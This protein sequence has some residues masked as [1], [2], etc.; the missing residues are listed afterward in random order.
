MPPRHHLLPPILLALLASVVT[1]GHA[2]AQGPPTPTVETEA[3][4]A[5]PS[6][7]EITDWITRVDAATLS[8]DAKK[9]LKDAYSVTL[10]FVQALTKSKERTAQLEALREDAPRKLAEEIQPAL[11]KPAPTLPTPDPTATLAQWEQEAN[12]AK[13]GKDAAEKTVTDLEEEKRKRTEDRTANPLATQTATSRITE[14]ERDLDSV[15]PSS[16]PLDPNFAR[17]QR[18][19]AERRLLKQRLVELKAELVSY[20]ARSELLIRRGELAAKLRKEAVDL[21]EHW[22][23]HV[24]DRRA[25]DAKDEAERAS[26]SQAIAERLGL[27]ALKETTTRNL[28]LANK[29][30]GADSVRAKIDIAVQRLAELN[31]ERTKLQTRFE[32][33]RKRVELGLSDTLGQYLHSSRRLVFGSSTVEEHEEEIRLREERLKQVLLEQIELDDEERDLGDVEARVAAAMVE[34]AADLDP[35]RSQLISETLTNAYEDLKKNLIALQV[36]Y[37]DYLN[38]LNDLDAQQKALVKLGE[39]YRQYLTEKILWIRSSSAIGPE[40]L[41]RSGEALVWLGSPMRARDL[42]GAYRL[43]VV[44]MWPYYV[45]FF[46]VLVAIRTAR[47]RLIFRRTAAAEKATV[48]D[49]HSPLTTVLFASLEALVRALP[50]PTTLV[51]LAWRARAATLG[52]SIHEYAMALSSGVVAIAGML[53]SLGVLRQILRVRGLGETTFGWPAAS[54]RSARLSLRGIEGIGAPVVFVHSCF[55]PEHYY[56]DSL[57]RIAFLLLLGIGAFFALRLRGPFQNILSS[58]RNSSKGTAAWTTLFMVT[59]FWMPLVLAG[60]SAWGYHWTATQLSESLIASGWLFM[61]LVFAFTIFDQ[62]FQYHRRLIA[63]ERL[64]RRREEVI[65][66]PT[67]SEVRSDARSEALAAI[68][69][70]PDEV[71]LRRA[72]EQTQSLLRNGAVILFLVGLW[73]IWKDVLPALLILDHVK[74][75]T[76]SV[77]DAEVVKVVDI[78]LVNLLRS[79]FL[80]FLTMIISVNVTGFL[81]LVVLTRLPLVAGTRYAVV[82]LVRYG[83]G[84]TGIALAMNAL[85][86]NWGDLKWLVAA[87]MV[88]LGFGLQEIFGNLVSG[89]ILLL[90]RPVR[91]GDTVTVNGAT[92]VVT[93]IRMRATTIADWDRKELI[94]PNKSFITNDIVNW[95]LTDSVIRVVLPVGVAYG[96]DP[97]KVEDLLMKAARDNRDVLND[98]A[99][100]V[101][102][103]SFGDNSLNFDLRVFVPNIDRLVPARHNMNRAIN[104]LFQKNGVSIPFPQR[105]VHMHIAADSQG[106][107]TVRPKEVEAETT[108]FSSPPSPSPASTSPAATT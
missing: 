65:A 77:T 67:A 3:V 9:S 72:N 73:T 10:G 38:K 93:R 70:E 62:W 97:K 55:G 23:H 47:R 21:S 59:G 78:T 43:D 96:T 99:P 32:Q 53:F 79:I 25:K 5:G 13:A 17:R 66:Q 2:M 95:S 8:E 14:I 48:K 94:I 86:L 58:M 76:V 104:A 44:R 37:A 84:G 18:L 82:T 88:G 89:L 64:R 101:V 15:A 16:D 49:V 30:V 19:V 50:I 6:E 57:G 29:R 34:T 105:D 1:P 33:D 54:L 69:A 56:G 74:L 85:G 52:W 4:L 39:E 90:E 22:A 35:F 71:D 103:Q 11:L 61:M 75:W 98:P 24:S 63:L 108:T 40:T 60:L 68:P 42:V 45:L 81:D 46:G 102:F 20:D 87:L 28:E 92:G 26:L 7:A 107:I 31:L 12:Q 27:P 36:D 91:V 41:L 80:L 100:S 106:F 51:F 83:I